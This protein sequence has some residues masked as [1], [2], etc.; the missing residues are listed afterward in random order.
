MIGKSAVAFSLMVFTR[1]TKVLSYNCPFEK[2]D[3]MNSLFNCKTL[4]SNN[5]TLT[6][7]LG[8]TLANA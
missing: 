5:S 6:A 4:F 7:V 1:N 8:S 2:Y 3:N